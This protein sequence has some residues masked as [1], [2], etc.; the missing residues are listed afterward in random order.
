MLFHK[1]MYLPTDGS[2]FLNF[3]MIL[4]MYQAKITA[5]RHRCP[6][7]V[8]EKIK[9]LFIAPLPK[10]ARHFGGLLLPLIENEKPPDYLYRWK[11]RMLKLET[12]RFTA[13]RSG[14]RAVF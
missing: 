8:S 3:A 10:L 1:K 6:H 7:M 4:V 12:F 13:H 9:S 5:A 11:G 2:E 14:I